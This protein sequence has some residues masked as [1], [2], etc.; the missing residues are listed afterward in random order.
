MNDLKALKNL[1]F[2]RTNFRKVGYDSHSH[3]QKMILDVEDSKTEYKN[4]K[5]Y[6]S[7]LKKVHPKSSSFWMLKYDA[8][9]TFWCLVRNYHIDKI[10]IE[11]YSVT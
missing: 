1:G 4:G 10:W 6:K 8:Y 3:L 9:R 5:Q 7:T 2:K 11:D